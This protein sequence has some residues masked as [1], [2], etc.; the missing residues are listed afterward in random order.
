MNKI[1]LLLPLSIL[2]LKC[3]G[4]NKKVTETIIK[5]IVVNND[6]LAKAAVVNYVSEFFNLNVTFEPT[7]Q[8]QKFEKQIN[9]T[10]YRDSLW[11]SDSVQIKDLITGYTLDYDLYS[12]SEKVDNITFLVTPDFKVIDS[13]LTKL[14]YAIQ[15]VNGEITSLEEAKMKVNGEYPDA[16]W[17][18]ITLKRGKI[19]HYAH[20]G[21][22][23]GNFLT[24][25]YFD[26]KCETCSYQIIRLQFDAETGKVAS[27]LKIKTD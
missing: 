23:V 15:L 16:I 1:I 2:C 4:Q 27:E 17:K 5:E 26:G 21:Y 19:T 8:L 24:Y 10:T 14:N 9:K 13:G 6:S 11:P 18:S 7:F 20:K 25:Y 22:E 12:G 3:I